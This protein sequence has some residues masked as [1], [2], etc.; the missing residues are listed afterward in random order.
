ML[1][2]RIATVASAVGLHA[3][4]AALFAQAAAASG[5]P[6]KVGRPGRKMVDARSVL[7]VMSLG[8]KCGEQV[9]L[10][11]DADGDDAGAVLDRL[12]ELLEQD[13]DAS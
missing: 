7:M 9:E 12:A 6:V 1:T 10:T 5:M 3:R 2:S 4:P 11:V 8:V 13:M